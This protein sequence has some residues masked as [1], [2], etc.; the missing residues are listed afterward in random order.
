MESL[1][2]H[3]LILY[4]I[5]MKLTVQT[6]KEKT[7]RSIISLFASKYEQMYGIKPN[8]KWG[9]LIGRVTAMANREN[10]SWDQYYDYINDL[11][12]DVHNMNMKFTFGMITSSKVYHRYTKIHD[13]GSV[14]DGFN[15]HNTV[16]L[17]DLQAYL[18]NEK[19]AEY[20]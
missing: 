5:S 8:I 19:Y 10:L 20:L 13:R 3:K 15:V 18:Y 1:Q 17:A 11:C 16:N 14:R 7:A 4:F 12:S 6:S 2:E 9:P